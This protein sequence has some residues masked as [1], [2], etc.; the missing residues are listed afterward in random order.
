MFRGPD[1]PA[2]EAV[3]TPS[4]LA[5]AVAGT[6][7]AEVL[8]VADAG[9]LAA[10]PGDLRYCGVAGG[11]DLAQ[12]SVAALSQNVTENFKGLNIVHLLGWTLVVAGLAYLEKTFVSNDLNVN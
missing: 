3:R 8:V 2:A 7:L 6:G 5:G 10:L 12:R 11:E 1:F 9:T 4:L